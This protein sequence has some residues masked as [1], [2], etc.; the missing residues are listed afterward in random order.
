MSVNRSDWQYYLSGRKTEK[1]VRTQAKLSYT[2]FV[3]TLF[4]SFVAHIMLD[5]LIITLEQQT[6]ERGKRV[7]SLIFSSF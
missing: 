6:N 4:L 5:N 7:I 1:C 2:V 3:S